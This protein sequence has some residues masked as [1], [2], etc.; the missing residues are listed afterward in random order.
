MINNGERGD[1]IVEVLISILIIG[2][3][4][5]AAYATSRHNYAT[6]V[7]TQERSNALKLLEQQAEGL[8]ELSSSDEGKSKLRSLP[9][10]FCLRFSGNSIDV[11]R[12]V[13]ANTPCTLSSNASEAGA[14]AQPAYKITIKK[15]DR[16]VMGSD[17][18]AFLI[19]A[20]W[21]RLMTG[22]QSK[23]NLQYGVYL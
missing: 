10:V 18:M 20:T 6:I 8:R 7:D 3:V 19:E 4:M 22:G 1:T 2:L 23:V 15:N 5:V 21:D 17:G 14:D 16:V 11:K 12:N 9:E 13:G